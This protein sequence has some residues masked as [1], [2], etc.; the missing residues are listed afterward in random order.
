MKIGNEIFYKLYY[1]SVDLKLKDL[2]DDLSLYESSLET[3]KEHIKSYKPYIDSEC[4]A[5]YVM[6][7]T[8]PPKNVVGR[9]RDRIVIDDKLYTKDEFLV[10]FGVYRNTFLRLKNKKQEYKNLNKLKVEYSIY[11]KIIKKF[12]LKISKEIVHRQYVFKLGYGLG[13][14]KAVRKVTNRDKVNWKESNKRKRALLDKGL[15]PYYKEDEIAAIERGEKYEGVEWLILHDKE[16]VWIHHTSGEFKSFK[17][18]LIK[19]NLSKSLKTILTEF[20]NRTN[21][22][23]KSF[24]LLEIY[25]K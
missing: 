16:N 21:F 23:P 5:D 9:L 17:F 20:K 13:S 7:L 2:E 22:N 24:P 4:S 18:Q 1:G 6:L 11:L 14:L 10:Y 19:S 25:K 12:N 3:V 15:I 8:A